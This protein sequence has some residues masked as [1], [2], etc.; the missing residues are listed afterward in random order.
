MCT[1][2]VGTRRQSALKS[3]KSCTELESQE[4]RRGVSL[5]FQELTTAACLLLLIGGCE[6]SQ[7]QLVVDSVR[8]NLVASD[9]ETPLLIEGS[10]YS[11]V[12]ADLASGRQHIIDDFEVELGG[13][14]L[15]EV[16]LLSENE[17]TAVIHA[18]FPVGDH[19]LLV[20][21]SLEREDWIARAVRVLPSDS[22]CPR[23]VILTPSETEQYHP[24]DQVDVLY[25]VIDDPPGRV[26]LVEWT[27]SGAIDE[28][29]ER[30]F[31]ASL[32]E[33]YGTI[34]FVIPPEPESQEIV[35]VVCAED[36]APNQN[37]CCARLELTIDACRYFLDCDD[38]EFCNGQERC[39]EGVCVAGEPPDCSD[40]VMCTI[41]TCDEERRGC[42]HA[43]NDSACDD[44]L[45]CTGEEHCTPGIGCMPGE[46]PCD[47]GIECTVDICEEG[48]P[49]DCRFITVDAFC[50]DDLFCNGVE[51]CVLG[52]GC[53]EGS[54]PCEDP[55]ECTTSLCFEDERSCEVELLHDLCQD[56]DVC[57]I[58]ECVKGEG[59][60]YSLAGEGPRGHPTCDD[61]VDNDC[62][63][64]IDAIDTD[65]SE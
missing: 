21:D 33:Y 22:S 40:G 3:T 53:V 65:C 58:D 59:C 25:Y 57:T 13:I 11:P 1:V 30:S 19:D 9:R 6:A 54:D 56:G 55:F 23:V 10:F 63:G 2:G 18:D 41:D 5:Q 12:G 20:R 51:E 48:V 34:E 43:P 24:G 45:Y 36:D 44:L 46:P 49:G 7:P 32:W 47:D 26:T 16:V 37:Q 17:L 35:V 38:G 27:V 31:N 62:D 50:Q 14:A 8:P 4:N 29:G 52:Y 60:V 15:S 64:D 28:S 39:V 61:G 42:H